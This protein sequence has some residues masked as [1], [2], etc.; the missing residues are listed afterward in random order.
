VFLAVLLTAGDVFRC[1]TRGVYRR[2]CWMS[3]ELRFEDVGTFTYSATRLY[4][5]G[6][7]S[8]TYVRMRFAP[9]R[10][11]NG[12]AVKFNT[13]I[14][15]ADAELENLREHVSRMVGAHMA[16]GSARRGS[17]GPRRAGCSV[18]R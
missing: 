10:G 6:G 18:G 13:S 15:N 2:S 16:C 3:R 12:R 9:R 4:I 5:N 17:N 1:H 8:G 11:V 7:Y 14:K